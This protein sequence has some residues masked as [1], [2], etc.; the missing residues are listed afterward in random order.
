MWSQQEVD[1]LV[2]HQHL[3]PFKLFLDLKAKGLPVIGD[4]NQLNK[5]PLDLEKDGKIF[6]RNTVCK[7]V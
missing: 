3:N 2:Q 1:S 4:L 6:L 5:T 7:K